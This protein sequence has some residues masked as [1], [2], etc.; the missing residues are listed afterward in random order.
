MSH[1]FRN[2]LNPGRLDLDFGLSRIKADP[3]LFSATGDFVRGILGQANLDSGSGLRLTNE[4][5]G[6]NGADDFGV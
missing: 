6:F 4:L 2:W 3:N 1:W 5:Y